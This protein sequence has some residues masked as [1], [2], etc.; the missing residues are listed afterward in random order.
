MVPQHR[1]HSRPWLALGLICLVSMLAVGSAAFAAETKNSEPDPDP[2]MRFVVVRSD[3]AGCEPTCPEWIS[4]EGAISAKS[5]A[6]LK[7]ALKTL[8][9][10]KLPIVINSPGGDVD[11][12]IAMGRMIRK[13]KLDIAVGRT[14]FV[15]CEPGV[16]NCKENDARGAHYIGSPYVLG[17]YCASACPMMLAGGTRRLVGPLAYLGVHQITTTIVQMNVQ[18]Q[19]RY[20]IVKGKKRVISKKVVSRKN[21]GSYKTYEMSKGVERKLSAYFKEMGVDLSIIETMK[22]TPASDIQQIDLSDMLTMKLV[23]SD[24]AA[25]L[26][27][28]ASLC[29]LNLP[30]PNCREI[31]ENKPAGG[32]PEVAKAAP[33]PVK[34]ESA[35]HDDGMR[36]V[37]VRGSNPLCNPD[38]PE[39]IAAQGAIT[40]QTPQKL[41]QLVATLGNR[42][43][44]VVISS[45][46]GDLSGAL[47]A[48]RIIHEKKLDV[49][50]ARTDFVGCD[51]AEWNCLAKDGAYAGLSVDGDGECDSACALMLAGGARRLVGSQARLSLY[52]MGQ[53]QAVKSYL[54]EMA[55]SPALFRALQGSSVERQLEPDMMLEVGLTTG[56]QSVDALTGSSICRSAPKPENCRV[57]PSS[58]G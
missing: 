20:R 48:G 1:L 23:T 14:W 36:F 11:A 47:A 13:N 30:A 49:A 17:S 2:P 52:L 22:S 26:L 8:G 37:V 50:V 6:L 16:K 9:G 34:P 24:D 44:P 4:A 55:I 43:L 41:S 33:L 10:R 46:G 12:A 54:D 56:R 35:P 31:P 53:K 29:R 27:T 42:R 28:S 38:C 39:W 18:Y 58:N 51:P 15:G 3:A 25:D 19:V 40:P 5:P 7:A 57:V 45:R 32:L 21:T